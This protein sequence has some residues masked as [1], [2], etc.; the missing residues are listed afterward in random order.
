MILALGDATSSDCRAC[1]GSNETT[2][3]HTPDTTR[4]VVRQRVAGPAVCVA[5]ARRPRVV[6]GNGPD[7]ARP[8]HRPQYERVHGDQLTAHAAVGRARARPSGC[9]HDLQS[10]GL[11]ATAARYLDDNSRAVEGV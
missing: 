11:A 4:R 1:G 10:F 9:V 8:W 7:R 3:F 6:Y 2:P 5:V